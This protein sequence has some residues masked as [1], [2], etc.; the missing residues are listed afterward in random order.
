MK[1]LIPIILLLVISIITKAQISFCEDFESYN[2]GD[3]IAQTS[4]QW[5]SWDELFTAPAPLP[6]F[7]DDVAVSSQQNST[8]GGSNS[9][10][11]QNNSVAGPEDVL[12]IFD[13]TSNIT[14]QTLQILSTPY[15]IGNFT[16]SKKMWVRSNSNGA[17]FNFQAE[18]TPGITWALEV[19]FNPNLASPMDPGTVEMSNT[20][21]GTMF[22]TSF[23]TNTWFE[24]KFEIDLTANVWEVFI[25]NQSQG[26]F[27]N[28]INQIAS[29][30][31]YT[32]ATGSVADEFYVDDICWQYTPYMP[33]TYNMTA[34]D[35]NTPAILGLV[36]APF[37][38]EGTV[39][40]LGMNNIT[41]MDVNYSIN[42]GPTV[43]A[44][45]TGLNISSL[46]SYTFTHPTQWNPPSSGT[47]DIK[48]WASNFNNGNA[49]MDTTNDMYTKTVEVWNDIVQ[50]VPLFET[51]TSSTCGPC[52]GAN[53]TAEAVFGANVGSLTSIKYQVDFPGFG[54]PYYTDEVGQ[55]QSYYAINSVP[56]MEIDGGWDQNGGLITQQVVDDFT[57]IP[58]RLNLSASYQITGQ[59]LDI[60]VTIDPVENLISN[61]LVVHM[62]IYEKTTY[63]NVG[64]NGETQFEHVVKKMVPTTNGTPIG[65][66]AVGQQQTLQESYTFQ[67]SYRLPALS[68]T[69]TPIDHSIEHSVEDFANLKV[70]VWVQDVVTKEIHQSTD[71]VVG[72]IT[73]PSWNCNN[74][75]CE[76]PGDGSGTYNTL[77]DCEDYCLQS[78]INNIKQKITVYPNPAKEYIFVEG[79][80]NFIEVYDVLG[81]RVLKTAEK[82]KIETN[83]IPN[84]VY[85]VK[86]FSKT[87]QT[88]KIVINKEN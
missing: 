39:F 3:R 52:A 18:N 71:A 56:R 76:D 69:S 81:E 32:R 17:Y 80:Y 35:I 8:P 23:P 45:L 44:P 58:S 36:N 79:E 83:N 63:N 42:G 66:L 34:T 60:D 27:T 49:D 26:S 20:T 82:G 16:Y 73:P 46:N 62:A 85:F 15:A 54:D 48:I 6:P 78:S 19:D 31:L 75:A 5:N 21:G 51:F 67:G 7:I 43:T 57:I 33:L 2:A 11:F 65:S 41:S 1:K 61:N 74:N 37:D 59:T 70:A 13:T 29:M 4:P 72:S 50:R 30:D 22:T 40:N 38:I 84:G 28:T 88:V 9:L 53:V 14:Q 64:T 25:D 24:I 86:V 10:Y 77:T 55:R 68:P 12:L 47:Y 87:T